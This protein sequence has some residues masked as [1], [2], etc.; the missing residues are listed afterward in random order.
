MSRYFS[1]NLNQNNIAHNEIC[2]T[3]GLKISQGALYGTWLCSEAS[4]TLLNGIINNNKAIIFLFFICGYWSI[5]AV[6]ALIFFLCQA[7]YFRL[8]LMQLN[9]KNLQNSTVH[10][11]KP[12]HQ[13]EK[14]LHGWQ[15]CLIIT[16]S[17]TIQN[18]WQYVSCEFCGLL[19]VSAYIKSTGFKATDSII[20]KRNA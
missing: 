18:T 4:R 19:N 10:K 8:V 13:A 1:S 20:L 17:P 9:L 2:V 5:L 16:L 15:Q 6:S 11:T 3:L 14:L 12:K 7:F